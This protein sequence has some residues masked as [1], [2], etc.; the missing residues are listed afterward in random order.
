MPHSLLEV[1]AYAGLLVVYL[2]AM[3]VC[4]SALRRIFLDGKST[5]HY[6]GDE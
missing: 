2:I 3:V 5:K 1:I 6:E 4:L